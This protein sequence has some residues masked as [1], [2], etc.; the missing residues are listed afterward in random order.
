[1]NRNE[2]AEDIGEEVLFIDGF[3]TA[4]IGFV[5]RCGSSTVV[6]YDRDKCIEVL[7][8]RDGMDYDDAIQFFEFNIIGSFVGDFTPAF[9]TVLNTERTM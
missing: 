1:M 6:L 3:D 7:M 8:E 9:A 5:E 2:L 4:I